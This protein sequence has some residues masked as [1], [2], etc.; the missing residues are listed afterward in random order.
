MNEFTKEELY[1]IEKMFDSQ[2]SLLQRNYLEWIAVVSKSKIDLCQS[3]NAYVMMKGVHSAY[4]ACR[5]ISAKASNARS[6][7][8][9]H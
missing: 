5:T 2:A 3:D 6:G 9:A 4:E 1:E 7:L 8:K